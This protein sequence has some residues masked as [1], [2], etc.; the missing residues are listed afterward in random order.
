MSSKP[1]TPSSSNHPASANCSCVRSRPVKRSAA[2][3]H[4]SSSSPH[5]S[6]TTPA[7]KTAGRAAHTV[8][9]ATPLSS[10]GLVHSSS[11]PAKR[12]KDE[13]R[14]SESSSSCATSM[15]CAALASAAMHNSSAAVH[16]TTLGT[17]P[18]PVRPAA[19]L[20]HGSGIWSHSCSAIKSPSHG[21]ARCPL[22]P[23]PLPTASTTERLQLSTTSCGTS[24]A[25][26]LKT[27]TPESSVATPPVNVPTFTKAARYSTPEST[28]ASPRWPAW[29][30][31]SGAPRRR[32][33]PESGSSCTSPETP[34]DGCSM[35]MRSYSAAA[36]RGAVRYSAPTSIA[37]ACVSTASMWSAEE[38]ASSPATS[39][40]ASQ[41]APG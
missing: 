20:A 6:A 35:R 29:S 19:A 5:C 9:V 34:A 11:A 40:S 12:K 28:S 30:K 33:S 8:S 38:P 36:S 37:R 3:P 24:V 7:T 18:P 1:S 13:A 14:R 23:V 26:P 27:G 21:T 17:Q 10:S 16:S 2:A 25:P 15:R 4:T 39:P 41:R 31:A 32:R 22:Q